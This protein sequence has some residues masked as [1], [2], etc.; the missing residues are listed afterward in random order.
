MSR[1]RRKPPF[2]LFANMWVGG[3]SGTEVAVL[4]L[5]SGLAERG[6]RTAVY[7]VRMRLPWVGV[8][9][10]ELIEALADLDRAPDV[11]HGH[12][13]PALAPALI[14]FPEAPAVQVLHDAIAWH[15]HVLDWERVRAVAAVDEA[16]REHAVQTS[17]RPADEIAL[18][19]NA[20]ALERCQP[21]PPLPRRPAKVLVV[22]NRRSDH[23]AAVEAACGA[24]GLEA[25]SVG[26]GVGRPST[27]LEADMAEA[28]IVVGA[29]RI[30]LEA[31]AVGCAALVCDARGLAG[32]ATP[33]RFDHWRAWNFGHRLLT[34][35]VTRETVGAAIAAYDVQSAAEVTRRVRAECGLAA[36]L[37]RLEAFYQRAMSGYDS[38]QVDRAR[39]ARDV[40]G[41]L[42][43]WLPSA[44][45][46]SPFVLEVEAMADAEAKYRALMT[47]FARRGINI[48]FQPAPAPP[49]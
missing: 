8:E 33:E 46:E 34:Q 17:G 6:W 1:S 14:R 3:L 40:D 32:F 9:R 49:P 12:Q 19:P 10:V 44:L 21:R 45:H 22:A 16:C 30:A 24:A 15:D 13:H 20:L 7:G 26:H 35:P 41:Y 47:E 25:R 18:L 48:S 43:R 29:A 28:D 27:S 37:D 31:M 11:I 23:V 39:E 5:A 36:A 2:A 42:R 4:D 38:A